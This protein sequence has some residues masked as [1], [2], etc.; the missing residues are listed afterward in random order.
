SRQSLRC[1]RAPVGEQQ[2]AA[3]RKSVRLRRVRCPVKPA[4]GNECTLGR[5]PITRRDF[6]NG[7]LIGSG[8]ALL[9]GRAPGA[10]PIRDFSPS[11]SSWTGYG[12]IGDYRW[13]NG[14]TEQVRDAAHGIRDHLYPELNPGQSVESHAL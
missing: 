13:S 7:V 5:A 10:A 2:P 14:N 3:A 11:G 6:V 4:E 8:A 12:G 9:S 1:A